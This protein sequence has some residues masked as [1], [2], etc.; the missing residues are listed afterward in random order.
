MFWKYVPIQVHQYEE[1]NATLTC[2]RSCFSQR[3]TFFRKTSL[4]FFKVS[5]QFKK[6]V[7]TKKDGLILKFKIHKPK[8][9][10]VC[11]E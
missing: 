6:R 4:S 1:I 3:P 8:D 11:S 10:R 2:D 5:N 7:F 9:G